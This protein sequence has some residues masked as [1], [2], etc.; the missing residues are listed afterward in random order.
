MGKF[1][2]KG[3]L[4]NIDEYVNTYIQKQFKT[5]KNVEFYKS[6]KVYLYVQFDFFFW[7]I[8]LWHY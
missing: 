3:E 6:M 7:P 2:K 8:Y 4:I 5:N 1:K